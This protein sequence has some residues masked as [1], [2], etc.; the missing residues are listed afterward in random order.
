MAVAEPEIRSKTVSVEAALGRLE[1]LLGSRK[2]R[3]Q[4]V[5]DDVF[6]LHALDALAARVDD[7]SHPWTADDRHAYDAAVRILDARLGRGPCSKS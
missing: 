6:L 1:V 4:Q 2:A 5:I 7:C 3:L